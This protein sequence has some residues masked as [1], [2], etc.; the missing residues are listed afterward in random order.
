VE[1]ESDIPG[2]DL[3]VMSID[4][5]NQVDLSRLERLVTRKTIRSAAMLPPS[6]PSRTPS[7]TDVDT[8]QGE[9]TLVSGSSDGRMPEL[10]N[11]KVPFLALVRDVAVLS[12]AENLQPN[13]AEASTPAK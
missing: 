2:L 1:G 11:P 4:A 3:G 13:T 9:D 7:V 10:R 6:D 8:M 5:S 12:G